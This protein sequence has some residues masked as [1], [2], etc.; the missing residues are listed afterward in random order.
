MFGAGRTQVMRHA[1]LKVLRELPEK[2]HEPLGLVTTLEP[3][4]MCFETIY[5]ER[6][7]TVRFL[8]ADPYGGANKIE[9]IN[10]QMRR[11]E[12]TVDG[13]AVCTLGGAL[14]ISWVQATGR[15]FSTLSTL[16][17]ELPDAADLANRREGLAERAAAQ[18]AA[19]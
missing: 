13:P 4:A 7:E 1:E 18:G 15:W 19:L 17:N 14:P 16:V 8:C 10:P 11:F 6:I 12:L 2:P 9:P 5:A 3:C